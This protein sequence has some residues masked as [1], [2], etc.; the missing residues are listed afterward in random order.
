MSIKERVRYRFE[1]AIVLS[2]QLML[3][4]AVACAAYALYSL[5]AQ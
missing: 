3:F 5:I 4:W 2:I 1:K